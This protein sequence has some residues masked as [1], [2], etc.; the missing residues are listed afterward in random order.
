M[1]CLVKLIFIVG[2]YF[3]EVLMSENKCSNDVHHNRRQQLRKILND[4]VFPL[5]QKWFWILFIVFTAIPLGIILLA[6]LFMVLPGS[7]KLVELG[8]IAFVYAVVSGYFKRRN[9]H[10]DN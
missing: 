6:W 3:S 10:K 5:K 9:E 7:F 1:K 4:L 2:S 8:V